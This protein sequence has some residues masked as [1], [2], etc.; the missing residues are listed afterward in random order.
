MKFLIVLSSLEDSYWIITDQFFNEC[1]KSPV[2]YANSSHHPKV[3][4]LEECGSIEAIYAPTGAK[5]Q[6]TII[7]I[8]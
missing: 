6:G 5:T 2:V 4:L 7:K 8:Q 3:E 1:P